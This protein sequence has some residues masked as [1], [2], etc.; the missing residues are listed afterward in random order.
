M[1]GHVL[2]QK[3]LMTLKHMLG[4][5]SL[6]PKHTLGVK[7]AVVTGLERFMQQ[8]AP[9]MSGMKRSADTSADEMRK[10]SEM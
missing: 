1:A 5:K 3:N 2:G 10:Q 9:M 6:M 8:M 4:G 7:P